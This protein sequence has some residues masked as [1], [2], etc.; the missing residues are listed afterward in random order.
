MLRRAFLISGLLGVVSAAGALAFAPQLSHVGR[1]LNSGAAWF[2]RGFSR[3]PA[4]L[5]AAPEAAPGLL[6][7]GID[8][9]MGEY[10]P[11]PAPGS[12]LHGSSLDS[13]VRD[14]ADPIP[15]LL[16]EGQSR[17]P[18]ATAEAICTGVTPT[19]PNPRDT[20]P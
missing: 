15:L 17:E 11:F 2:A 10:C 13:A 6:H 5:G 20:L 16:A 7:Q 3:A 1:A 14:V 9:V 4:S 19:D 12:T 8:S 18:L